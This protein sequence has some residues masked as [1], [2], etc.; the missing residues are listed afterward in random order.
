[1][2]PNLGVT[3]SPYSFK[4]GVNGVTEPANYSGRR[5]HSEREFAADNH[6]ASARAPSQGQLEAAWRRLAGRDE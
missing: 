6:R 1:M 4:A 3:C 2:A 5:V